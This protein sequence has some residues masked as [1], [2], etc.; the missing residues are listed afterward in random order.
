MRL[1]TRRL[2]SERIPSCLRRTSTAQLHPV[3]IRTT[4]R[5]PHIGSVAGGVVGARVYR[6]MWRTL[7][8]DQTAAASRRRWL[9]VLADQSASSDRALLPDVRRPTVVAGLAVIRLALA[10]MA[11]DHKGRTEPPSLQSPVFHSNG[12]RR[13]VQKLRLGGTTCAAQGAMPYVA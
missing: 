2:S 8:R 5:R 7:R 13:A 3:L 10:R 9:G 6:T 12:Q 4:N 1:G 11:S